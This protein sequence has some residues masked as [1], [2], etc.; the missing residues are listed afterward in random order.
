MLNNKKTLCEENMK[1]CFFVE[2]NL[3]ILPFC[4]KILP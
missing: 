3:T 2:K 4:G 1:F